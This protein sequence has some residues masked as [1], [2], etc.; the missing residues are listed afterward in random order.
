MSSGGG[1]RQS[2]GQS[3]QIRNRH[4]MVNLVRMAAR[5]HVLGSLGQGGLQSHDCSGVAGGLAFRFARKL[6][7][8][9]DV[10]HILGAGLLCGLARPEVVIPFGQS[11][12]P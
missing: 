11:N 4:Q 10:L 5:G 6:Q 3:G 7:H 9:G 8:V 2:S 1:S 12:A